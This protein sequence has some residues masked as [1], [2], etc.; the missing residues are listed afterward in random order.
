MIYDFVE[1][2]NIEKYFT[3]RLVLIADVFMAVFSS[4]LSI[5]FISIVARNEYSLPYLGLWVG[6][7]LVYAIIVFLLFKTSDA[8]WR[9]SSV[10][11][12]GA[13]VM[14]VAVKQV[15][16]GLTIVTVHRHLGYSFPHLFA[17]LI[18]DG[19]TCMTLLTV[20]KILVVMSNDVIR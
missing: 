10:R 9:Y 4:L 7:S 16:L 1:K 5:T 14:A 17:L 11:L 15:C 3:N 18:V 8:V 13:L 12:M 6:G 20:E 2:T 19:L